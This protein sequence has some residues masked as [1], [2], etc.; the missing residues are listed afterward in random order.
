MKTKSKFV[1][2]ILALSLLVGCATT[3][4]VPLT[5]EE[6]YY[7]NRAISDALSDFGRDMQAIRQR[8]QPKITCQRFFDTITCR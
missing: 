3:P 4:S 6:R 8:N 1:L 2:V 5:A 7:R